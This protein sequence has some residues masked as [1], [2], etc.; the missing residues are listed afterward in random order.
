MH[1]A[2]RD[3]ST[4]YANQKSTLEKHSEATRSSISKETWSKMPLHRPLWL[5]KASNHS[6]DADQDPKGA[7]GLES[8]T[9]RRP[10]PC[11][12]SRGPERSLTTPVHSTG[13]RTEHSRR[14]Q[15]RE[16]GLPAAA[17]PRCMSTHAHPNGRNVWALLLLLLPQFATGEDVIP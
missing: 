9:P 2:Q 12:R 16:R 15:Q 17:G 7:V 8:A 10:S 3:L 14:R 6:A 5:V 11:T 13:S 1:F 4:M